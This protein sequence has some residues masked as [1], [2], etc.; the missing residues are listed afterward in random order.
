MKNNV[1]AHIHSVAPKVLE[2]V[3][4]C[5]SSKKVSKV[6]SALT[7]AKNKTGEAI[8]T[9]LQ[10]PNRRSLSGTRRSLTAIDNLL[11]GLM[12]GLETRE[13]NVN[14]FRTV[15]SNLKSNFIPKLETSL[16]NEE[17]NFKA[18]AGILSEQEEAE[19]TP[20]QQAIRQALLA[21]Q[22]SESGMVGRYDN[23]QDKPFDYDKEQLTIEQEDEKRRNQL[24]SITG[25]VERR[26]AR[27]RS[28]I[29]TVPKRL[30][31]PY[32]ILKL[33]I[34]PHFE[35]QSA[36]N[37]VLLDKLAIP[38][39]EIPLGNLPRDAA[40]GVVRMERYVIFEQQTVL[41][42]SKSYVESMMEKKQGAIDDENSEEFKAMRA[43]RK[44]LKAALAEAEETLGKKVDEFSATPSIEK[45]VAR[46]KAEAS[47]LEREMKKAVE[48][49]LNAADKKI[50]AHYNEVRENLGKVNNEID[51]LTEE[52][53]AK[54]ITQDDYAVKVVNLRK[55]QKELG[56]ARELAEEAADA[57]FERN[58]KS[59]EFR[60]LNKSLRIARKKYYKADAQ[61][62][63]RTRLIPDAEQRI[64]VVTQELEKFEESV[65]AKRRSVKRAGPAITPEDYARSVLSVINERTHNHYDLVS[66]RAAPNPHIS[67]N[68]Q[69]ILFF[70]I[71]PTQ[72]LSALMRHTGGKAKVLQWDFP[73]ERESHATA[74][75]EDGEQVQQQPQGW[76]HL[77]DRDPTSLSREDLLE[78]LEYPQN[79]KYR[80]E[81]WKSRHKAVRRPQ[82]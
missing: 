31:A 62:R 22:T 16:S 13:L 63:A 19:L 51:S 58:A 56:E 82:E 20:Q 52:L 26:L 47:K 49:R 12:H 54:K 11:A 57:M 76:V 24:A 81:G 27:L 10:H 55:R 38:H 41:M 30:N 25:D 34:A 14:Q 2:T 45:E 39:M 8:A 40:H 33:P 68:A 46:L 79:A 1:L 36:S 28:L 44:K 60:D 15:C 75:D 9:L 17:E 42:V 53:D 70:W 80:P 78:F 4:V 65:K 21:H 43:R 32:G 18:E 29:S 48:G 66:N 6:N 73:F 37:P 72:K 59:K 50:L 67:S 5:L 77:K 74:S 23:E 64:A 61:E 7:E 71:M 35:T 3:D 69:D